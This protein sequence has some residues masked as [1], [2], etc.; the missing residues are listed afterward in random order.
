MDEIELTAVAIDSETMIL[1]LIEEIAK[2]AGVNVAGFTSP[3][4]ASSFIAEND[5][6]MIFIDYRIP[7]AGGVGSLRELHRTAG[8]I[9]VVAVTVFDD[10]T[11]M[12][13]AMDAGATEFVSK[14]V[15]AVEFLARI[16]SLARLRRAERALSDR[17]EQVERR[18][19]YETAEFAKRE[20]E[21][22]LFLGR[23]SGFGRGDPAHI[24]R[25]A[26]Y[27]RLIARGAGSDDAQQRRIFHAALL[28]DICRPEELHHVMACG[29][30]PEG[31]DRRM[32]GEYALA[33]ALLDDE[34]RSEYLREGGLAV[35]SVC[36]WFDGRGAPRGLKGVEIPYSARIVAIA[37]AFDSVFTGKTG[38]VSDFDSAMA[39]IR[40]RSGTQF[41]P[42]LVDIFVKSE[43]E[44]RGICLGRGEFF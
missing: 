30:P 33:G 43:D 4:D 39:L 18:V 9:P 23:A 6:D 1:S 27:A 40:E 41:D 14:P 3:D 34:A 28:H 16:R 29:R 44:V 2:S 24:A 11:V 36:E 20:K 26:E 25:V 5:V 21:E 32:I 17:N 31:D 13:E 10:Y 35:L 22:L 37:D 12:D 38:N 7:N 8:D 19:R 42:S 15:N